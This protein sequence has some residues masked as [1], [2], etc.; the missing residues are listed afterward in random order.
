MGFKTHRYGKIK[1][2]Y[3][4]VISNEGTEEKS[5]T[6]YFDVIHSQLCIVSLLGAEDFS[7][8][9]E[10]TRFVKGFIKQENKR[11]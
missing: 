3:L 11:D 2:I 1:K 9:F 4:F 8:S 5:F 7:L 10:M 6:P